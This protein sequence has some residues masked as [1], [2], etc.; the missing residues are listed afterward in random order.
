MPVS[1]TN[2]LIAIP[3]PINS[4]EVHLG[5]ITVG[6]ID[7]IIERTNSSALLTP[8]E[9]DERVSA[10][11]QIKAVFP[12]VTENDVSLIRLAMSDILA[13]IDQSEA[14]D[15]GITPYWGGYDPG[16]GIIEGGPH[17][18]FARDAC[19]YAGASAENAIIAGI[20]GK[21]PD[22][23][24][25]GADCATHYSGTGAPGLAKTYANDA[26]NYLDQS[27]TFE[28]FR[29]LAHSIHMMSDMSQPYHT[30]SGIQN[31]IR[32]TR[33][34]EYLNSNWS[35]NANYSN[36]MHNE[37]YYYA[38]TD[39]EISAY[40]LADYIYPYLSTVDYIMGTNENTWSSNTELISITSDCVREATRYC[41][42]TAIYV[43]G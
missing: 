9:I 17:N 35:L 40:N 23:W 8:S 33:Y 27:N 42:G 13:E 21:E 19:L 43:L 39:V 26:K 41:R 22:T 34:E 32:H 18:E 28:G 4:N 7:D 11:T 16:H 3:E 20:Y 38:V 31:Y 14:P 5:G 30:G 15:P 24:W 2:E 6:I 25:G 1:A 37:P 29:R 10:L 12:D 36:I